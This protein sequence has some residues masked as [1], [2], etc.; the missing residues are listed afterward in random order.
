MGVNIP[1]I[2]EIGAGL[3][4]YT[5][6]GV[7]LPACRIDRNTYFAAWC[8]HLPAL[9]GDRRR[10]LFRPRKQGHAPGAHR[11]PGPRRANAVVPEDL[12]DDCTAVGV[13]ARIARNESREAH[14][15]V[16][17]AEA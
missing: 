5:W 7:Y 6:N 9:S 11:A 1:H 15:F 12:P 16:A 2:V 4:I 14:S 10:C 8:A 17:D 3:V 13:P